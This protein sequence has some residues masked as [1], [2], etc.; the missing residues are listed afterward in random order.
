MHIDLRKEMDNILINYGHPIILQKTSRKIRCECWNELYQ[1]T[2][3]NCPLCHGAAWLSRL[4]RH[5]TRRVDV[6]NTVSEPNLLEQG[7][8]GLYYV[9]GVAFYFRYTCHPQIGDILYEVGWN[10]YKPVNLI[11]IYEITHVEPER[12][13][14]G[15]IEYFRVATKRITLDQKIYRRIF[16]GNPRIYNYDIK[17]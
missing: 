17:K 1:E 7:R 11:E 9:T 2:E 8:I 4:E 16:E 3:S 15:R 13:D 6:S 14:S 5:R 12:A 10:K